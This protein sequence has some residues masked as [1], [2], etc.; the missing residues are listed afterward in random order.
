MAIDLDKYLNYIVPKPTYLG[1]LEQAGLI[2]AQ[3][4]ENVKRQ[5]AFQGLLGAGLSYLAQP[6]NQNYG[7]VIPYLAKSAVTGLEAASA[8]YSRLANQAIM[9]KK[10]EDIGI[11]RKNRE[12][13]NKNISALN[14]MK[15]EGNAPENMQEWYEKN[16]VPYTDPSTQAKLML[17]QID[18]KV[19]GDKVYSFNQFG[20]QVGEPTKVA[21]TE[22]EKEDLRLR[23]EYYDMMKDYRQEQMDIRREN[24]DFQK[25]QL[26]AG[27]IPAGYQKVNDPNEQSG[28][29]Y[30]PV[31][32]GPADIKLQEKGA[33]A[34]QLD[35][36]L[37][38]LK[39][40][41]NTLNKS[42]DIRSTE[43]G[44]LENIITTAQ[45][46]DIGQFVGGA[47]GTKSQAI[48]NS[49]EAKR[50]LILQAIKQ[51]TGMSSRQMDSNRELQFYLAAATDPKLGYEENLKAIDMLDKLFVQGLNKQ[52][53]YN[54]GVDN[55][56][57]IPKSNELSSNMDTTFLNKLLDEELK[58]RKR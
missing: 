12:M 14:K 7:S 41:Y 3:D 25:K 47:V 56:P 27:R 28:F 54:S 2:T 48:R 10:I 57:N 30:E 42:G 50:P 45:T 17:P 39:D 52:T 23:G 26:E 16:V 8:P 38:S 37:I 58:K 46:S 34:N 22:K 13:L 49:I 35:S 5:S 6:K 36:L 40:D 18:R 55:I 29:R 9:T 21:L 1:Q 24:L 4:L 20:E 19:I 15:S 31:K 11:E 53:G 33:A 43:K 32:G 44:A 51:A